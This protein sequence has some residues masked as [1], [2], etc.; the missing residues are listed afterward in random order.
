MARLHAGVG[1][2]RG[3]DPINGRFISISVPVTGRSVGR[4]EIGTWYPYACGLRSN[5]QAVCFGHEDFA[6]R[7]R[8]EPPGGRFVS[9][10]TGERFACALREDGTGACWGMDIGGPDRRP[11]PVTH[12]FVAIDAGREHVCGLEEDGGVVCW[13][14]LH[15]GRHH[16]SMIC[17]S[18]SKY[19]INSC[20]PRSRGILRCFLRCRISP[21][22][23]FHHRPH[24]RRRKSHRGRRD[25]HAVRVGQRR[26]G[27]CAQSAAHCRA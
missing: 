18:P 8:P 22:T 1:I 3:N 16:P 5:G 20:R 15:T 4:Q 13:G 7:D 2:Y 24:R 27:A 11:V 12:R 19:R 14:R 10:T 9:I 6:L 21:G 23:F 25:H 17:I 26:Q